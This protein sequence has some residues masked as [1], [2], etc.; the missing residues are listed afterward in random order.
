MEEEQD[1]IIEQFKKFRT[2]NPKAQ[3]LHEFLQE[4]Q[5]EASNFFHNFGS[6]RAL[7]KLTHQST[8]DRTIQRLYEDEQYL[9]YSGREKLL[10]FCFTWF[11]ELVDSRLYL[12]TLQEHCTDKYLFSSDVSSPI[13]AYMKELLSEAEAKGEVPLR[14]FIN[15]AYP[16]AGLAAI[17]FL[18]GVWLRDTSPKFSR[19]DKAV[20]KTINLYF[21]LICRGP[22]ESLQEFSRLLIELKRND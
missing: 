14:L 4:S 7:E 20:E 6:L 12:L 10:A 15:N 22:L 1:T 16:Q 13:L 21:D 17:K 5:I 3:G 2:A 19:T 11:D 8:V 18:L 9:S